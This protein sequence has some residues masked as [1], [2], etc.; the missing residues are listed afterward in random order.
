MLKGIAPREQV[1]GTLIRMM[2]FAQ[3]LISPRLRC[4]RLGK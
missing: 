3:Y 1:A 2:I 4:A